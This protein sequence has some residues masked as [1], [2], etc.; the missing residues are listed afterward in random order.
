MI[1]IELNRTK[2]WSVSTTGILKI[3]YNRETIFKCVTLENLREGAARN[4]DL[5]IPEGVYRLYWRNSPSKGRKVHVFN[6]IVPKDRYI[7]IHAGNREQDTEGCILLGRETRPN[8]VSRS[9]NAVNQFNEIMQDFDIDRITMKVR[10][11]F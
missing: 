8:W 11:M 4:Q 1:E 2:E 10:D 3:K 9:R 6:D 7:M 5:R